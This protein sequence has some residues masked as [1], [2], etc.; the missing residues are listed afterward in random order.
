MVEFSWLYKLVQHA[1]FVVC[2]KWLS[3]EILTS[4]T[5]MKGC[6]KLNFFRNHCEDVLIEVTLG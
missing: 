3:K 2:P 1:Q 6:E 4:T 5:E